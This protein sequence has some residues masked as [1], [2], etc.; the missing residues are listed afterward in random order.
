MRF[1]REAPVRDSI[2]TPPQSRKMTSIDITESFNSVL[3]IEM[4]NKA[5]FAVFALSVTRTAVREKCSVAALKTGV[6]RCRAL[7]AA[8]LENAGVPVV[9]RAPARDTDQQK[10]SAALPSFS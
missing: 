1:A 5:A 3:Q 8:T 6:E 9:R 7:L 4:A 10:E 2:R